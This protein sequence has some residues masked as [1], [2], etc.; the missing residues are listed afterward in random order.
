MKQQGAQ[1][2]VREP[3]S[4]FGAAFDGDEAEP[5][6]GHPSQQEVIGDV[7]LALVVFLGI[8]A[9]AIACAAVSGAG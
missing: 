9:M 8:A 7:G 3:S 6:Q 4:G 5:L 2:R 1:R